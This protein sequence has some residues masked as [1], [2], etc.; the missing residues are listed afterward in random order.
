MIRNENT[1]ERL[2]YEEAREW[3]VNPKSKMLQD[4]VIR[5]E[6]YLFVS[7]FVSRIYGIRMI[8][9][10]L[11]KKKGSTFFDLMTM[12]DFAYTVAVLE[13]SYEV[14]DQQGKR[15]QMS[16]AQW[17]EYIN[18][19]EYIKKTPKFTDR[20]GKKRE[21]CDSGWTKAGIQFFDGVRQRWRK[22]SSQNTLH[23]WSEL[24]KGWTEYAEDI[25]FGN[26]YT[27]RKRSTRKDDTSDNEEELP[28]DRFDFENED[29][30]WKKRDYEQEYGS[31][32][33]STGGR[34]TRPQKRLR[35]S[36]IGRVSLESAD[37]M[38]AGL[39][40]LPVENEDDEVETSTFEDDSVV[41]GV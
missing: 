26:T 10:W 1:A 5:N 17:N 4:N 6:I 23:L 41:L 34:Y 15:E 12:S 8:N 21:Y 24:E 30:P 39:P 16:T 14:W 3:F 38:Q 2:N 18:S 13:N 7:K 35:C 28:P 37:D 36:N 33:G 31:D 22:L 29:C 25:N 11:S 27:R 40:P 19:D 32:L 20:K 9:A